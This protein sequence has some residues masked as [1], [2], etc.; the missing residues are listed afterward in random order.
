MRVGVFLQRGA[1]HVLDRAVVAEV[2]DFGALPWI[3]RRMMLIAASWPSNRLAAV[4][5][6]SGA[7]ERPAS[8]LRRHVRQGQSEYPCVHP[9]TG[10][11]KYRYCQNGIAPRD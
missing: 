4:T 3:R 1:D 7:D 6:R 5:K 11:R 8:L 2:D 9:D 10:Y